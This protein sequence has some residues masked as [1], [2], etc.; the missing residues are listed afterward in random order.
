MQ[1]L[2]SDKDEE[3]RSLKNQIR[4]KSD[5]NINLRA[6]SQMILDQRSEVF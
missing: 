5:E 1:K 2:L 6:L 3:I 4:L